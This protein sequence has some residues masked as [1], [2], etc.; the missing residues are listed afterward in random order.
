MIGAGK[1]NQRVTIKELTDNTDAGGGAAETWTT[2]ATVWANIKP[3]TGKTLYY[4]QQI[5]SMVDS[6][7]KIRYLSGITTNMRVTVDNRIFEINNILDYDGKKR[8]L[9]LLA[10][11]VRADE[12]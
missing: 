9:T 7:I 10:Q 12:N 3:L 2:F 8:E 4:A 11:E 5:E 6:E 1:L